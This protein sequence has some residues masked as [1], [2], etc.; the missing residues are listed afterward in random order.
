MSTNDHRPCHPCCDWTDGDQTDV[1][2]A[3]CCRPAQ[4]RRT[5]DAPTLPV[6]QCPDEETEMVFDEE[7]EEYTLVG[8]LLDEDCE[9]ILDQNSADILVTIG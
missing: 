2:D 6:Q 5:C 9:P 8:Q 3:G 4:I 1:T 7:T